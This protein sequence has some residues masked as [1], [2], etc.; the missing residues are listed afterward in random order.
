MEPIKITISLR[1]AMVT[2]NHLLH[3]DALLSGLHI[4][5]LEANANQAIDPDKHQHDLP[6]DRYYSPSGQWCFKASAF[7]LHKEPGSELQNRF[8]TRRVSE[9]LAA[10]L[11]GQGVLQARQSKPNRAGGHFKMGLSSYLSGWYQATAFMIADK[12]KVKNLLSDLR[13]LG[14]KKAINS[15]EIE[16]VKVES[17]TESE[18]FWQMRALP[19]DFDEAIDKQISLCKSVGNLRPP[20]WKKSNYQLVLEPAI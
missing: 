10:E 18:C 5:Q 14:A 1:R 6:I 4:E 3:S 19:S 9:N 20:Y 11:I 17:V 2:P 15:G 8:T 13:N 16:S 7:L 12:A